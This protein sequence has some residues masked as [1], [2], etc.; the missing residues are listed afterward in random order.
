MASIQELMQS[1][2]QHHQAG[3]LQQAEH[4]YRQALAIDPR[5]VDALHML[6]LLAYQLGHHAAACEFISQA[7]QVKPD[8]AEAHSNLGTVLQQLGRPDEAIASW[9]QALRIRPSMAEAYSNLGLALMEQGHFDE[10]VAQLR[11]AV[12]LKPQYAEAHC[13]LGNVLDKQ[14]QHEAAIGAYQQALRLRPD[15]ADAYSNLGATLHNLGRFEDAAASCRQALRL[16]PDSAL[17]HNNLGLSLG[18]QQ[19]QEEA[20]ACYRAALRSKPEFAEAHYNLGKML[21]DRHDIVGAIASFRRASELKAQDVAMR[22]ALVHALQHACQWEDLMPLVDRVIAAVDNPAG[23]AMSLPMVP[24]SFLG[25]PKPTTAAQQLRC[26]R[27]WVERQPP[28][29]LRFSHAPAVARA[30]DRAR[31][32]TIGYLSA[33]FHEHAVAYLVVEWFERHN[34][35]RFR[36]F[37]YSYGPD[38]GSPLRRRIQS[39]FDRFVELRDSSLVEAATRIHD[40]QVDIL[41]DLTGYT[42]DSRP[43]ILAARPAPIQVNYMGY[44]GTMAA[45]YLDYILVDRFIV[46]P[47][48]QPYFTEKLVHLPGCY[49]AQDSQCAISPSVP[50][51]SECGLPAAGFVFCCFNNTYKITPAMF[52]VWMDLLRAVPGSVLWLLDANALVCAN[53]RREAAARGIDPGRLVFALRAPL[54]DHLAR[55]KLA[56]L[57]L[58]CFPYCGHATASVSLWA[59]CPLLTLAG[60]TMV[61][62]VAGSLLTTIGLPELVASSFDEYAATALRLAREPDRLAELRR[63]L[64]ANRVTSGLFDGG[65]FTRKVERAYEMMWQIYAAGEPPRA[66]AVSPS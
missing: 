12:R 42:R 60:Q 31:K 32:L 30:A 54:A 34:R 39:A 26:T 35:D 44:P 33:D 13:N 20:I 55:H 4:F 53:L 6:G 18:E 57:A 59:G 38:D 61:S 9:R 2:V 36:V 21:W 49:Q 27:A 10:A 43:R 41:V 19:H 14:G 17:A 63:R 47:D 7:L 5:Q 50:S 56:D 66:F 1:A 29:P 24:F 64:E 28:A 23:Q 11:E 40:D 48:Q 51:R 52:T 3:N 58:D 22:G 45:P 65:Q 25:L 37:G 62:R 8:F 46:P 16:Q 15:Y